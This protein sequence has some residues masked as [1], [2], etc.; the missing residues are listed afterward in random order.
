MSLLTGIFNSLCR[1]IY[2][3]FKL[4]FFTVLFVRFPSFCATKKNKMSN[5]R[6][7]A[8]RDSFIPLSQKT[9]ND[10]DN[11]ASVAADDEEEEEAVVQP[12][13]RRRQRIIQASDN[14]GITTTITP[15]I[16]LAFSYDDFWRSM[17]RNR[18]LIVG[19]SFSLALFVL[20]VFLMGLV[21]LI[22]AIPQSFLS[23]G[24]IWYIPIFFTALLNFAI[25]FSKKRELYL[26]TLI[27][28]GGALFITTFMISVIIYQVI[29]CIQGNGDADCQSFY[30]SRFLLLLLSLPMG[31]LLIITIYLFAIVIVRYSQVYM[32]LYNQRRR[33]IVSN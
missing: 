5:A 28:N 9:N 27:I 1:I 30:F 18:I 2:G 22:P 6:R 14:S 17:R 24:L 7:Q 26:I 20:A 32:Q 25:S 8:K 23:Y 10:D 21:R 33:L 3:R 13:P 16:P 19:A 12:Q 29:K 4:T 31:F 11:D 15:I